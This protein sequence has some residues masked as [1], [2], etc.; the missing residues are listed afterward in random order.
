VLKANFRKF[1]GSS[2]DVNRAGRPGNS[3]PHFCPTMNGD[4]PSLPM[5]CSG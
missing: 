4:A 3:I 5:L 1:E 2:R